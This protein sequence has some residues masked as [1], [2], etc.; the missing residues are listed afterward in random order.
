[1]Q[2]DDEVTICALFLFCDF[3]MQSLLPQK[4]PPLRGPTDSLE[5]PW[6]LVR[7]LCAHLQNC[8]LINFFRMDLTPPLFFARPLTAAFS[9]E[10]LEAAVMGCK[11]FVYSSLVISCMLYFICSVNKNIST[12]VPASS[13]GI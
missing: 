8:C 2:Q 4:I 7:D 3:L 11:V 5:G 6:F 10:K 12:V 9:P 13:F 1:M